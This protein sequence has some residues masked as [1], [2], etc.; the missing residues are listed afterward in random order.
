MSS[1][2]DKTL[3][4]VFAKDRQILQ[5]T[6]IPIV[7]VS[8]TFGE[9]LKKWYGLK[10]ENI[11]TDIV[12]SRAHFSMAYAAVTAA[13]GEEINQKKAWL[14]D[15]TNFVSSQKWRNITMTEQ[16]GKI[17]ARTPILKTLKDLIDK[18]GRNKLPILNS[19][20]PPLLYLFEDVHQ[21]IL[22]FHIAA[23][24]ILAQLGKTVV[25]VITDPHVREDYLIHASLPN[26]HYCVFDEE[27]KFEAL[28]K[29]F[30][31]GVDLDPDRVIVTGPPIDQRIIDARKQKKYDTK[32]PLK[33]LITTGGLGTNKSEIHDILEQLLP[34][35][36]HK[37]QKYELMLYA[38]TQKDFV[39]LGKRLG[40]EHRVKV[41]VIDKIAADSPK[42]NN[43]NSLTILYHPQIFDANEI[44]IKYGFPWADCVVTKPSGDMAYDAAAAGCFLITLKPW[45][46]WEERIEEIFWQ[47]GIARKAEIDKIVRQ[48]EILER[49][50]WIKSAQEA[51]QELEPLYL[52]GISK[53]IKTVKSLT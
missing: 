31:N 8:G 17:L 12:F 14:V 6:R 19:I 21:P 3:T 53:I 24:N 18:F 35:L 44:L 51:V 25:Q 1:L 20:T 36:H 48:F 5:S 23:G 27:T 42:Q 22:C 43:T 33:I 11:S 40:K 10:N 7:T 16:I 49:I 34:T 2:H 38:G 26:L 29:A 13:W 41:N 46:V 52:N 39:D 47:K 28:E 15:P 45:G 30:M 4:A 50:G 9:D 32:K 37:E